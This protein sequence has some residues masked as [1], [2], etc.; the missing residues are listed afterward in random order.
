M[1]KRQKN[2]KTCYFSQTYRAERFPSDFYASGDLL[3][4][5]FCQNNVDWKHA[6]AC[7]GHLW[8]LAYV[9]NEEDTVLHTLSHG[10]ISVKG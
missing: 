2:Y 4:C 7:K 3:F 10:R 5:K 8:S 1:L 6:D 9:K